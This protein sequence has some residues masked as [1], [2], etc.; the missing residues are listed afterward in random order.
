MD[1]IKD[2]DKDKDKDK[3]RGVETNPLTKRAPTEEPYRHSLRSIVRAIE[4]R[5]NEAGVTEYL[6]SD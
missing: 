2:K 6:P 4:E 3:G 1:R 5:R